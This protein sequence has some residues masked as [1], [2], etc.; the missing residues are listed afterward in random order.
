VELAVGTRLAFYTDGLV[1]R[2]ERSLDTGIDLLA[3]RLGEI[4]GPAEGVPAE[5]VAA[6]AADGTEDDV[7][8]LVAR[9]P[10]D[11]PPVTA[12]MPIAAEAE[13]VQQT[14]RFVTATLEGWDMPAGLLRDAV[15]LVSEMSTNAIIHGQAPIELRLRRGAADLLIEVDDGATSVPRRLRPTP[16]DEHGRG[17]LLVAMLSDRWGT[18]PLRTGKSVW[19]R[20]SFARYGVRT[21]G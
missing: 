10:E 15:L 4:R 11:D 5:L 21:T 6:V 8:I 9:V 7:A 12:S 20:L 19:C 16:E 13:M 14:R 17:L 2:R 1:E 18:R 3:R